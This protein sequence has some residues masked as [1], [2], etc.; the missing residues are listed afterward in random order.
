MSWISGPCESE[1]GEVAPPTTETLV[2]QLRDDLAD[3]EAE[4]AK[5][6]ASVAGAYDTGWAE[7]YEHALNR[8]VS[9]LDA[10]PAAA[11]IVRALHGLPR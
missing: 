8:A 11:R 4:V 9:M 5:A 3:C 1:P 7:G 2:A 6:R 10:Y